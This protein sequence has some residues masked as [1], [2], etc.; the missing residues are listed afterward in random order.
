MNEKLSQKLTLPE[1]PNREEEL[2]DE[3]L[4]GKNDDK[5]RIPGNLEMVFQVERDQ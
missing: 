4:N 2:M 3:L 1:F 5:G